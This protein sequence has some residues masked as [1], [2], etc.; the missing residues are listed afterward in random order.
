MRLAPQVSVGVAGEKLGQSRIELRVQLRVV[1]EQEHREPLVRN[2]PPEL[3]VGQ[4]EAGGAPGEPLVAERGLAVG[5]VRVPLEGATGERA[6][7][8][9]LPQ[10][11]SSPVDTDHPSGP[12]ERSE[13]ARAA[14]L[15]LESVPALRP[16]VQVDVVDAAHVLRQQAAG[17]G[18]RH[19]AGPAAHG[20]R[21]RGRRAR[22]RPK[23][24]ASRR[25]WV[26][27]SSNSVLVGRTK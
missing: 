16:A 25:E 5:P 20:R 2:A 18:E 1:L 24:A 27:S 12:A 3:Q 9:E 8:N 19:W 11:Q 10:R 6:V 15:L 13:Q 17:A 7:F 14:E 26:G 4:R 22:G 23:K 21:A